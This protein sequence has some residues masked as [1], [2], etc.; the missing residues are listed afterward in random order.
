[1]DD[2]KRIAKNTLFMYSRMIVMMAVNLY[3]VR[4]VLATLGIDNYGL[5]NVISGFVAM[6]SFL[7]GTLTTATQRYFSYDI[8][9]KNYEQLNKTFSMFML[10]FVVLI[11]FVVFLAETIGLWYINNVMVYPIDRKFAV[12]VCYQLSILT[13]ILQI[14]VIPFNAII[15]ANERMNVFAYLSVLEAILKLLIVYLLPLFAYD[16][17]IFYAFLVFCIVLVMR[18]I[19]QYYCVKNFPES[20]FKFYW[21]KKLF[22]ELLSFAGWNLF[23][24]MASIGRNQ[25]INVLLNAFFGPAVN[26]ARAISYQIFTVINDFVNNFMIAV[27]PQIIKK[28]ASNNHDAVYSLVVQS[29]KYSYMLILALSLP[30]F[31]NLEFIMSIWLKEVPDYVII[32]TRLV[33]INAFIDSLSLPLAYLAQATGDI[34]K[35]QVIVGGTFLLVLP[36]S[37]IGLY[38]FLESPLIPMYVSIVISVF[39]QILRV[40]ELNRL[41]N[42]H[43]KKYFLDVI[44]RL[45]I[46]FIVAIVFPLLFLYWIPSGT[47]M[48]FLIISIVS[49]VSVL[50]TSFFIGLRNSEKIVITNLLKTK[51]KYKQLN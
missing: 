39:C 12:N 47:W 22:S 38:Y 30:V 7:S 37:W 23:G 33:L 46:V 2:N 1:M 41:V 24:A 36:L 11:F 50:I 20:R 21:N 13:F 14:L 8:G 27:N 34:K 43:I 26:A 28:H 5:Y 51:L 44:V 15:V 48:S 4:V 6:F 10:I 49:V 31:L 19:Y 35:Y 3:A 16:K 9:T 25:G 29:S 32:F 40:R 45:L 17:L 18:G 42:F